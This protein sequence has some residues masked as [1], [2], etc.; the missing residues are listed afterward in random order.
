MINLF[1]KLGERLVGF[2]QD[3][4]SLG[5]IEEAC[6][7]NPWFMP[8]EVIYAVDAIRTQ[9]LGNSL[10]IWAANT[11]PPKD[12]EQAPP[13]ETVGVVMA[14]NIPLVGFYDLMCVLLAG[15]RCV[16]KPSS[17]DSILMRYVV[18][19][20]REIDPAV[21]VE[22]V[23]ELSSTCLA[24][25][26]TGGETANKHFKTA[27]SCPTLLRGSRYSIAVVGD[28]DGMDFSRLADDIFTYSGLGCRSVSMVFVPK[29]G[30]DALAIGLRNEAS[31]RDFNPK[32]SANYH[33]RKAFRDVCGLP[34]MDL[35]CALLVSESYAL[36]EIAVTE[37]DDLKEVDAWVAGH[38]MEFQCVV[39]RGGVPFGMAQH[40][41]LSDYADGVD[42]MDFLHRAR[43]C[44]APLAIMK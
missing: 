32:Y 24:V 19:L 29:G 4:R 38:T 31:R 22:F 21:P 3:A 41:T 9:Y 17:K 34:Y 33:Q 18:D 23:T 26:A 40:P 14:G 10:K 42:V 37:Y 7:A 28:A 44:R 13:W 8:H 1:E 36:S 12:G 39:G 16:V 2:G 5:V 30:A 27:F 6:R 35:G 20:L 15:Y 11:T 43:A 25:I